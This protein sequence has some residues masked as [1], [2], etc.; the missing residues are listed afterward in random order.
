MG[1]RGKLDPQNG[2]AEIHLEPP[3]LGT[4][5]VSLTLTNGSLTAQFQSSSDVVRNLLSTHMEKLKTALEGQGVAVGKIAVE[6]PANTS[7]AG[8]SRKSSQPKPLQQRRPKRE[9]N[10][11]ATRSQRQR[12]ST[13]QALVPPTSG[14]QT[15]RV[16]HQTPQSTWSP[17]RIRRTNF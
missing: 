11:T 4:L 14:P 6:P 2:K 5:H 7:A 8:N 12:Q 3:N 16:L 17:K 10:T 1:L 13:A 9:A 15:P